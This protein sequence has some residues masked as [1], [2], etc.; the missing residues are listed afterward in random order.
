MV[1]TFFRWLINLLAEKPLSVL[2]ILLSFLL[3]LSIYKTTL[4]LNRIPNNNAY[5]LNKTWFM[6]LFPD[7]MLSFKDPDLIYWKT[8]III[9]GI[10]AILGI[11]GRFC[12]FVLAILTFIIFGAYEGVG[13]FDHQTS[14]LSQATF[15]LAL[16]PGSMHL[17]FDKLLGNFLK[18]RKGI[19]VS[20]TIDLKWGSNLLLILLIATYFTAGVS[21]IRFG[22]GSNYFDGQTI[23]FYIQDHTFEYPK[24]KQKIII[25]NSNNLEENDKWKDKY[26]L[27][28]YAYSN[29][30][31]SKSIRGLQE[32]LYYQPS[33]LKAITIVSLIFELI[34]FIVFFNSRYRNLYLAFAI[35]FHASIGALMGFTFF[36]F[37]LICFILMD[38]NAIRDYLFSKKSKFLKL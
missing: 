37:Q 9:V 1:K 17:S 25:G 4:S 14:F 28:A 11:A 23:G 15:I 6:N 27:Q 33:I 12:L 32:W 35:I 22:G 10:G 34:G 24:G 31:T 26:G 13:S 21:K 18:K 7:W 3:S 5:E 19:N 2:R 29:V 8:L 38:W 16:V 30:Q 20:S 36:K